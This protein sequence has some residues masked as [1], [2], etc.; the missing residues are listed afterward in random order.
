LSWYRKEPGALVIRVRLTPKGSRDALDGAR[1][2]SDGSEVVQARVRAP[3][4]DGAANA[5]LVKLLATTLRVPKSA[6]EIVTGHSSRVKQVRIV[7][8]PDDLA[9]RLRE[10]AGK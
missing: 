4:A 7:G 5:A 3:P 1:I 10:Q 8:D 6:V 9:R 2:L